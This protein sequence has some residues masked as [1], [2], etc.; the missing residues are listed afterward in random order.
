[1]T[2][3]RCG[4]SLGGHLRQSRAPGARDCGA[5]CREPVGE[6]GGGRDLHIAIVGS[7]AGAFA[8]AIRAAERGARVTLIESAILGGTCVNV[9]C[10]PSK[11]LIRAGRVVGQA[12][13]HG[14]EGVERRRLKVDNR[15]R[16][17][18]QQQR[19][20]ALRQAK[21]QAVLEANPMITLLTGHGRLIDANTLAVTLPDGGERRVSA[22][23]ILLA[24]GSR[25]RIPPIP[26]LSDTPFWTSTE[27]LESERIPQHL[28]V[29]GG[30]V[31]ALE[32]AQAYLQL[33][34]EVTL[35]TRGR[36][37]SRED[38]LIG[39]TLAELL[40][41]QGMR[42]LEHCRAERVG[43]DQGLFTL[44]S[45][46]GELSGDAL[47]V[48]AGRQ[49]N[50]ENLGL[51]R[52]GVATD[53]EGRIVVDTRLQTSVPGIYA[54][55]DCTQLPRFVYVAAAAGT[56]AAI[57]MTGGEAELDLSV[58]PQVVFTE[59]QV[60][61]VGLDEVA[62]R[63]RGMDVDVRVLPMGQVPRALADFETQ[64]FIKLLI[65]RSSGRLLGAQM[66]CQQAAEIVQTAAAAIRH[67]ETASQ[68]S[69][70]LFVYLSW[71]EGLKLA[72]QSFYQELDKLSCCSG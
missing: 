67:G 27:A 44:R 48:A 14:L 59:P 31:V 53:D 26:G 43:Y 8:A 56:R 20:E 36:L 15:L 12:A 70:Q 25:A 28:L 55:G 49:A 24:T 23:R 51:E 1:M 32:L 21:Y 57:N 29:L 38:S 34:A 4:S 19:V 72:A 40:G 64:G 41:K 62:A 45:S 68:L 5:E 66:L 46:A 37:L 2:S 16:L 33:G 54:V 58:L 71:A 61:S 9:G 17:R 65:E 7:G 30:S 6:G 18:Q 11:I 35:L 63:Q 52:V 39:E 47:L 13:R 3:S 69:E 50:S 10:V 22:D 60:A 42:V